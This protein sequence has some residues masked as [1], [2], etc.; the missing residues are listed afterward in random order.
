[1]GAYASG[2]GI[3]MGLGGAILGGRAA[4]QRKNQLEEIANTPGLDTGAIAS[5]AIGDQFGN[6]QG[7]S[8]LVR[9]IND[10]SIGERQDFLDAA[11]P[12]YEARKSRTLDITDSFLRGEIPEDV[13]RAIFD[14]A[15][16]RS[17]SGGYGG[18]GLAGNL[19]ARDFGLTS[20]GLMEK[21]MRATEAISESTAR[22]EGA[23]LVGIARYLGVSPQELIAVRSRERS[24]K[25]QY[26]TGATNAPGAKDVWAKYLTDAGGA[27]TGMGLS[28][29]G[30]GGGGGNPGSYSGTG[31]EFA[32]YG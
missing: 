8:E 23:E 1:M 28:G 9:K 11:V 31:E 14:N 15:A 10:F 27:A 18:S 32:A 3:L 26:M 16:V 22:L 24:E 4:N 5:E 30:V 6:F 19:T 13:Q 2:A 20:L 25:M 21:G 29:M 17:I 12:G 7:A